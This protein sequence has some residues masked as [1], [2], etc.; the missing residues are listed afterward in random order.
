MV[1]SLTEEQWAEFRVAFSLFDQDGDG[2]ITTPKDLV[3]L[4][5]SFGHTVTEDDLG[6]FFYDDGRKFSCGFPLFVYFIYRKM[7]KPN[8][9]EL[10][11][12]FKV[13]D[14]DGNGL[15]SAAELRQVMTKNWTD[16]EVAEMIRDADVDSDGHINY[17]EFVRMM[18]AK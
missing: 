17:E 3:Q 9:E 5:D 10:I 4:M 16:E 12:A 11:R 7:R 18:R 6:E 1:D 2:D 8:E 14:R 13:F 15:I